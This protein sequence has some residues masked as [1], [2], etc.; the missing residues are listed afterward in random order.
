MIIA[1]YPCIG[2][3][4]L[5][6]ERADVI[7]LE[8]SIFCDD[9]GDRDPNW[10]I[11]YCKVAEYLSKQGYIV[12]VSSH[13]NV[14]AYLLTH[15]NEVFCIIYPSLALRDLW[16][17]KLMNRY[18]MNHSDK[19]LRAVERATE[20][21]K[22]DILNII[23]LWLNKNKLFYR[24][25]EIQSIN[26]NLSD[27]V[28]ILKNVNGP[29]VVDIPKDIVDRWTD[30]LKSAHNNPIPIDI[31]DEAVDTSEWPKENPYIDKS[32]S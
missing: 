7:D 23:D 25:Y 24:A 4:S 28:N 19:N 21:Y 18:Q 15:T 6:L 20:F 30:Y 16:I 12:F 14:T 27:I 26:Y 2:K 22:Q 13:S 17:L 3:S 9:K 11:Q 1:G 8:S 29:H 31:V 5:A 32:D 10:Y